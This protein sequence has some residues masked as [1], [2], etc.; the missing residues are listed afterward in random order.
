MGKR[1][2]AKMDIRAPGATIITSAS[3]AIHG[4]GL[5]KRRLTV[6]AIFSILLANFR[7]LRVFERVAD[8]VHAV[9]VLISTES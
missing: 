6:Q 9:T 4:A 5:S 2:M 7:G 3:S 1:P 8:L